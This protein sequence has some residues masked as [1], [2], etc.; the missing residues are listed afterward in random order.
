MRL[1]PRRTFSDLLN[2]GAAV[3]PGVVVCKDGSMIAAWEVR[4]R[5]TESLAREEQALNARRL[6]RALTGFGDGCAFWVDFRRRPVRGYLGHEEEYPAEALKVLQMERRSLLETGGALFD[7]VI[8]LSFQSSNPASVTGSSG[9]PSPGRTARVAVRPGPNGTSPIADRI[10]AFEAECATVETRFSGVYGLR[11][12]RNSPQR[13]ASGG[14]GLVDE[15]VGHLATSVSGTFMAPRRPSGLDWFYL[16]VLIAPAFRQDRIDDIIQINDRWTAVIAIDGYPPF[17]EPGALDGLQRFGFEYQWSSRFVCLGR[18]RGRAEIGRRRRFWSQDKQSLAAQALAIETAP[19]DGFASAME[20]DTESALAEVN[21]GEL[22]YGIFNGVVVLYGTTGGPKEPVLAAAQKVVEALLDSGFEARIETCNALEAYLGR[23]P[24]HPRNN[25]RR[26]IL[27]SLNVADLVPLSTLWQGDTTVNCPQFPRNAPPLLVGRAASGEPYF[28]NLHSEGVGHTLLFG[29]TG[30]GKSA[31]LAL[32][33]AS[34][35]K[36][37]NARV[38]IFDRKRSIRYLT[39]AIGGTF[40][41]VG[42]DGRALAPIGGLL[43][44]GRSHVED[45][46]TALVA[47]S[48]ADPGPATRREIRDTV[49][50]LRPGHSIADVLALVQS[51]TARSALEAYAGGNHAGIFDAVDDGIRISDWTVFET[52]ALFSAGPG[53]AALAL[54]YLFRMVEAGLDGRPTLILLDEA[55][56]FLDHPLFAR[57]IRSWLKELRKAN[58]SVVMATQSVADATASA[59]T[60]VL[61]EN[62]PTRI[63]LPNPAA[64]SR[65]SRDQYAS[66]GVTEEMIAIIATMKPKR[67]AYVVKPEGRRVVDFLLGPVALTLLGRTSVAEA[68]DAE[69]AAATDPDFWKQDL[70]HQLNAVTA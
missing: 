61:L 41:P 45:W 49:R 21:S 34:F 44:C 1:R 18:N 46:I 5:D 56:A 70:R 33:A 59:I 11:R 2:W 36:Y 64:F 3:A 53:V 28:F 26:P 65:A 23:L 51:E 52:E 37:P 55:W 17:T 68:A 35:T 29:P 62:C 54:D 13:L 8:H 10:Q 57:R 42:E 38:E 39:A 19:V 25:P 31:L 58:A 67:H 32:L 9:T 63:F 7:N 60:P 20:S 24:G 48:G 16:D 15:L 43:S 40:I 47:E 69:R 4:G 30:A 50:L 12:L 22:A 14:S 27:S 6:G 66:L